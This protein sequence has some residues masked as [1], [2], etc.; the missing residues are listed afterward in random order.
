MIATP[1]RSPAL[2]TL[3]EALP[4]PGRRT[5]GDGPAIR[6]LRVDDRDPRARAL[7]GDALAGPGRP[8]RRAEARTASAC[9]FGLIPRSSARSRNCSAGSARVAGTRGASRPVRS[10]PGAGTFRLR[11]DGGVNEALGAEALRTLAPPTPSSRSGSASP[12]PAHDVV[13]HGP[14]RSRTARAPTWADGLDADGAIQVPVLGLE[15]PDAAPSRASC[16]TSSPTRSSTWRTGSNCPTWLQE[17][18]AQWLEGGDPGRDDPALAAARA[19]RA[20]FQPCSPWRDPFQPCPRR[21][22]SSPMPRACPRSPTCCGSAARAGC[23][24]AG[25]PRRQPA[26]GGGAA[27]GPGPQL[28]GVPASWEEHLRTA[29]SAPRPALRRSRRGLAVPLD[30]APQTLLE[31]TRWAGSRAA[32][33]PARMSARLWRMSPARAAF[34]RRAAGPSGQPARCA[35]AAGA[36]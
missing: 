17:G 24:A 32:A 8:L 4:G 20:S 15:Q 26:V 7:L 18:V 10:S 36:A 25:G 16:A 30:R 33:G 14:R 35:A 1:A 31:A 23:A 12:R 34:A 22:R 2:Q 11:Y 29:P 21:R 19:G 28:S 27:R 9:D 13:L 5:R 3:A 6:A